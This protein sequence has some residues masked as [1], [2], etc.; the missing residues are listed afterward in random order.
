M[1]KCYTSFTI[2]RQQCLSSSHMK[3]SVYIGRTFTFSVVGWTK[4]DQSRFTC[5]FEQF[6]TSVRS[7]Q[8]WA[9]L[10][11]QIELFHESVSLDGKIRWF[12]STS[13]QLLEHLNCIRYGNKCELLLPACRLDDRRRSIPIPFRIPRRARASC[14]LHSIL[15]WNVNSHRD[16]SW[17]L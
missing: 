10:K 5:T 2:K 3:A 13:P 11:M 8:Q 12:R 16:R 14:S 1:P 7:L 4:I 15:S 9:V 17:K 6:H